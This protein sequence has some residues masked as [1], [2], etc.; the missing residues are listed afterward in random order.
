ML[1]VG[2]DFAGLPDALDMVAEAMKITVQNA[3]AR[4]PLDPAIIDLMGQIW[5]LQTKAAELSRDLLP[6]FQKLHHVD[7]AR[8]EAPRKGAEGERMWDVSANL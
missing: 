7:L 8:L 3:D 5:H 4:Q 6:A 1:Q 2:Q